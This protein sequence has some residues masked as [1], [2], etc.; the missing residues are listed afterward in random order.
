[1][2]L[3]IFVFWGCSILNEVKSF[4][5]PFQ[6]TNRFKSLHFDKKSAQYKKSNADRFTIEGFKKIQKQEEFSSLFQSLKPLALSLLILPSSAF[7]SDFLP[8]PNTLKYFIAGIS[9]SVEDNRN[10]KIKTLI[11]RCFKL[12]FFSWDSS[13]F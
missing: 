11:N 13:S 3:S 4:H 1:M 6:I 2:K 10:F 9:D 7:A 12:F 8:I 5:F